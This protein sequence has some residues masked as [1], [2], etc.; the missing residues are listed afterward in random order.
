MKPI[1][2]ILSAEAAYKYLNSKASTSKV[3]RSV[4]NSIKKKVELI[5]VN[6]HYGDPVSKDLMPV[7]YKRMLLLPSWGAK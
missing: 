4:F 1:R 2:V 3:D 6:P 7:E 5:K